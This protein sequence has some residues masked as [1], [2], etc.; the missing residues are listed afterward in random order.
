MVRASSGPVRGVPAAVLSS[1][2]PESIILVRDGVAQTAQSVFV[3][4]TAAGAESVRGVT[5]GSGY[6][7]MANGVALYCPTG[8]DIE[9]GDVFKHDGVQYKVE[10]VSPTGWGAVDGDTM[11]MAWGEAMRS[12]SG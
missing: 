5:G 6:A 3:D 9:I 10:F 4:F 11:L 1:Q 7:G 12:G 8:T 2:A